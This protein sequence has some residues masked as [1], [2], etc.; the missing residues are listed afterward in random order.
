MRKTLSFH[1]Y[2]ILYPHPDLGVS[3]KLTVC[4]IGSYRFFVCVSQMLALDFMYL[5]VQTYDIEGDRKELGLVV[6]IKR[7]YGFTSGVE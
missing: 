3:T 1:G 6:K 2:L 4:L 7:I 5:L